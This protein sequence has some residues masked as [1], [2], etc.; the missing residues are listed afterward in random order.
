MD[1]GGMGAVEEDSQEFNSENG[2]EQVNV[3]NKS[4]EIS[5]IILALKKLCMTLENLGL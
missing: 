2:K 5:E 1:N 4:F 3:L